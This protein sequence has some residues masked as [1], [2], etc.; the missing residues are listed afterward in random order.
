MNLLVNT[1]SYKASHYLQYPKNTEVISSYIESR[2]GDNEALCFFGLQHFIK[3]ELL[4]PIHAA[5][6][7]EAGEIFKLHG[8][9]FN[10]EGWEYILKVHAGYLPL[11]IEAVPEGMV[12]PI[13]NV[14]LQVHNTDPNCAWLTGYL[15]TALLR[16]IWYP[17]T[18]ASL[19]RQVKVMIARYLHQT[20][21]N[22]A[23]LPFKLH[24]FGARGVSSAESAMIGGLAHLVN[25]LGT[26]T[27]L[28][29]VAARAHYHTPMA[30]YSIP[31]AE[32]STITTWGKEAEVEAYRHMLHTFGAKGKLFAVVSDSYDLHHA[33]SELWGKKLKEEVRHQ[34]GT[35][36]VRPDSGEPSEIVSQSLHILAHHFGS[37]LNSKG[38]R[39]LPDYLRL[40]QGDGISAK[41]IESILARITQEGFSADNLA[42]GMGG[43]L[44]QQVNRDTL[45]FAMKTSAAKVAGIW[46]DVYKEPKTDQGKHSKRG[47]LALI[48]EDGHYQTIRLETLEARKNLL[49]PVFRNG[50]LLIDESLATIRQR[51]E[52]KELEFT[53]HYS[54]L[55][56]QH[57][58]GSKR[59]ASKAN[60][61]HHKI[62]VAR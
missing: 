9:P 42:F 59:A 13:K 23:D 2:G 21:D 3:S 52:L 28:A 18:V 46:R 25:F 44:L 27:A 35:L 7:E 54:D 24:D 11:E 61:F 56:G 34:G 12:L 60:W 6:I 15:E 26:D 31:A 39:M 57:R 30:G 14:L 51:A 62:P 41:S 48:C 53:N 37:Y 50:Q 58:Q 8:L 20:A 5:D 16:A 22:L 33:L 36:I 49:R 4:K 32:H 38:Y 10:R 43:A 55:D 17:T 40:I 19:S 45:R 47:R 29:L 1:D